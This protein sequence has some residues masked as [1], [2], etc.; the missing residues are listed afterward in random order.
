M[1][2]IALF[3]PEGTPVAYLAP[4][5]ENTFYLWWGEAVAYLEDENIY[6]FNG[7]HLGWFDQGIIWDRE[8]RRV[9]YTREALPENVEPKHEPLKA[10][11]RK[12]PYRAFKSW[13]PFRPRP[14][15][16]RSEMALAAFLA[17]GRKPKAKKT[18]PDE[19]T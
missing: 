6:G 4:E 18:E 8:C 3:D 1:S 15:V 7:K 19:A 12:R 13:V 11:K 14:S 5:E 9:G 10:Y 2:E 16:K 17:A